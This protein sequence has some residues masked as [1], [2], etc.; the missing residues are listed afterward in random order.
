MTGPHTSWSSAVLISTARLLVGSSGNTCLS[1]NLYLRGGQQG[2]YP[3]GR[4]GRKSQ[5]PGGGPRALGHI[6]PRRW[7]A[8]GH[9]RGGGAHQ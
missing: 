5:A 3:G 2:E 4:H 1:R 8:R 6:A 7:C 9:K